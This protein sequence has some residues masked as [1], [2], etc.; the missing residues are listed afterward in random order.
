M[1]SRQRTLRM[2]HPSWCNARA[3][4]RFADESFLRARRGESAPQVRALG[5]SL[6]QVMVHR[7]AGVSERS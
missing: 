7:C 6:D 4:Q 1:H 5:I 3:R 2:G